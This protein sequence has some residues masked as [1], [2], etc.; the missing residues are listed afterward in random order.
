MPGNGQ[1]RTVLHAN[2]GQGTAPREPAQPLQALV[3][4]DGSLIV[5]VRG[6]ARLIGVSPGTLYR[7]V[8]AGEF[9]AG[10]DFPAGIQRKGWRVDDVVAWVDAHFPAQR[11][12]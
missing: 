9:P 11:S 8:S 10:R 3:N 6:A 4:L 7:L 2:G 5:D 12:D 1:R